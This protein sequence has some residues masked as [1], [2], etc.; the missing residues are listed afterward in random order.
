MVKQIFVNLPVKDLDATVKFYKSLGFEFNAEFTSPQGTCMILNES[1]FVMLLVEDFF[2]SF[3][4][5][6]IPDTKKNAHVLIAVS[7]D[8]KEQVDSLMQ[9]ALENGAIE[10]RETQDHGFM[11]S[12]S[13]EDLNGHIFEPFWM[14]PNNVEK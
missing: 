11:Y 4:K 9:K 10:P 5:K 3:S 6:E 7:V 1:S 14:N 13:F 8:S 2:K 12:R